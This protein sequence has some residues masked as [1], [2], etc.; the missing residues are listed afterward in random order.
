M[1][2]SDTPSSDVEALESFLDSQPPNVRDLFHYALAM[3]M[4]EEGKGV[5]G[6]Q[7]TGA[8]GRTHV[9]VLTPSG[10]P[11]AVAKPAVSD[12][13]LEQM[14]AIVRLAKDKGN[15]A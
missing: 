12:S 6:E 1:T 15:P 10:D 11:F 3:L 7:S 2:S 9:Q 4:V 5:F 13:T 14:M 8:D